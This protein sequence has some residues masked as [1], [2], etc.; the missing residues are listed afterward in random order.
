MLELMALRLTWITRASPKVR[1]THYGW[2]QL[3]LKLGA[4]EGNDNGV[5]NKTLATALF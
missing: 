2:S 1:Q 5:M 4:L 3:L